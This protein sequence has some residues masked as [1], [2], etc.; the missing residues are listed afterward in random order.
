MFTLFLR[1]KDFKS[2][3]WPLSSPPCLFL[4]LCAATKPKL[5]LSPYLE[6]FS[7]MVAIF[8]SYRSQIICHLVQRG[9]FQNLSHHYHPVSLLQQ[10]LECIEMLLFI[11]LSVCFLISTHVSSVKA[12]SWP[13]L[14]N[15]CVHYIEN[16]AQHIVGAQ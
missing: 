10:P 8:S 15:S 14:L 9:H 16:H 6:Y 5:S 4:L 12:G 1:K 7:T 13:V 3:I 11:C 2:L